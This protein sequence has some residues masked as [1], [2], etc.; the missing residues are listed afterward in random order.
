MKSAGFNAL[1][2]KSKDDCSSDSEKAFAQLTPDTMLDAVEEC[3][4]ACDGRFLALNSYENRVYQIGLVDD[5]PI[6]AKFYRPNRWSDE[7]ILEE[8]DFTRALQD[9]ELAVIA[10]LQDG[11]GKSLLHFGPYRFAL[12]PC[13]GGRAPELDNF[14]HLQQLGRFLGRMHALAG[15]QSFQSRPAL[16]VQAF[17]VESIAFLLSHDFMPAHLRNTYETLSQHLIERIQQIA[18]AIGS[19]KIIRLH[20]DLHPGNILWTEKGPH[21]VDF[22]DARSGPAVQDIWMLLS[23]DRA[24]QTTCLSELMEAYTEFNDLDAKELRWIEPLRT[25]RMIHHAYWLAS[26]WQ[27]PAFP[28]AFPWFNTANYW[29]EHVAALQEQSV[30]LEQDPLVFWG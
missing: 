15:T 4:L 9:Q 21:L 17:G 13:R 12:Y 11:R 7:A 18:S 6:V 14:D 24:Y 1:N 28:L 25:L 20:G 3:G 19:M 27:D 29:E 30:M 16:S 2:L 26:R 23:G 10:P 8:H 5:A 22:D